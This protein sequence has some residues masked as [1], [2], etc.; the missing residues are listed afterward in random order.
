MPFQRTTVG[1]I[2]AVTFSVFLGGGQ[3]CCRAGIHCPDCTANQGPHSIPYVMIWESAS[4]AALAEVEC[5]LFAQCLH[6]FRPTSIVSGTTRSTIADE[7]PPP[8]T[9]GGTVPTRPHSRFSRPDGTHPF[10]LAGESLVVF[11]RPLFLIDSVMV[12]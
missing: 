6:M 4:A 5:N 11:K 7:T 8:R 10:D 2:L 9:L 12:Q 1:F 3:A